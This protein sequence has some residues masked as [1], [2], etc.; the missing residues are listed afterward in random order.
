MNFSSYSKAFDPNTENHFPGQFWSYRR[1]I[2]WYSLPHLHTKHKKQERLNIQ[3]KYGANNPFTKSMLYGEFQGSLDGNEIFEVA[4]INRMKEAMRE[5]MNPERGDVRAAGD[6]ANSHDKQ[7]LMIREGT[8]IVHIDEHS[9]GTDIEQ[10]EY[11]VELL[12][13]L[14]IDPW[15]FTLDG[16]GIGATVG[17][18]MELR[19]NYRGI[20]Y[21]MAN[22]KPTVDYQFYDKYTELHW[23]VKQLLVLGKLKLP[24]NQQLLAEMRERQYVEMD[25]E[26]IKCEPKRTHRKRCEGRSPDFLDTLVY[27]FNDFPAHMLLEG[28]STSF[29]AEVRKETKSREPLSLL[30]REAAQK[31]AASSEAFGEL[32]EQPCLDDFR[33]WF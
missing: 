32:E 10:A 28:L 31:A 4:D 7:V 2:D 24:F 18:Y 30:E 22:N 14:E 12:K 26:K 33:D 29:G 13:S 6:I 1:M 25:G 15:Q 27:L 20:N 3:A 11:W 17:N 8:E 5:A 16:G 19:L 21:F 23:V 9:R